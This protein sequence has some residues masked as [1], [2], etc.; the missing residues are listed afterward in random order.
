MFFAVYQA[1]LQSAT[2]LAG[3][4][5]GGDEIIAERLFQVSCDKTVP[6]TVGRAMSGHVRRIVVFGGS[7]FLG[8]LVVARLAADGIEPRVAVRHPGQ[9][10][11][12]GQSSDVRIEAVEADITDEATV[13]HAIDGVDGVVNA[14]GLYTETRSATFEAVHVHGA[15]NVARQSVAAGIKRLVHIS[16]IGV[17]PSSRSAYVR[18]RANGEVLVK[19]ACGTATILRPSALFGSGDG[20]VT[21]LTGLVRRSP[22][23]PLFGQGRTRLQPIHVDDVAS[24]VV[25]SLMMEEARGTTYELGGPQIYTYRAL[26]TLLI[27]RLSRRRLMVPVPFAIWHLMA[28]LCRPMRSPP[29]SE[30]QIVLMSSDNVADPEMPSIEDLGVDPLDLS[31]F[32]EKSTV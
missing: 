7:G 5:T 1:C 20:F 26:L 29:I 15:L 6:V 22:V 30:A 10:S 27:D 25:A 13:A 28:A 3:P 16:G 4:S 32:L 18:A 9:F 12:L 24:A 23:L 31:V 17:D 11:D 14:V 2:D 8:R 21:A 19:R